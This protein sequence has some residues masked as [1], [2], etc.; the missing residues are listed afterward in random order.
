MI[1][2]S[3]CGGWMMV[4]ACEDAEDEGQGRAGGGGQGKR[5]T[6]GRGRRR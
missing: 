3:N 2:L 4:G 1:V 6:E 5:G